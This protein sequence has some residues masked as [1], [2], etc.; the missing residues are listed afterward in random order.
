M[1]H[2]SVVTSPSGLKVG[3]FVVKDMIGQ[4]LASVSD[5]M[6]VFRAAINNFSYTFTNPANA[7]S[8]SR[9]Y[10]LVGERTCSASEQL[11]VGLKPV[12]DTVLVGYATCGKPVGFLPHDDSC[13]NTYGVVNFESV[14]A[15]GDGRYFNGLT[16]ACGANED[17]SKPLGSTSE[18]LLATALA[19]ADGKGCTAPAATQQRALSS[20]ERPR[21]SDGERP[22]MIA[23]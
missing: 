1:T 8:L 11:A 2:A 23:R 12:V 18:P 21:V 10:I 15:N 3:Y 17:W 9:V 16:P 7:L 19:H 4:A 22:A 20:R 14:N 5:A 6:T 13:G